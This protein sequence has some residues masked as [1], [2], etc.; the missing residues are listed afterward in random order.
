MDDHV[1]SVDSQRTDAVLSYVERAEGVTCIACRVVLCGHEAVMSLVTGFKDVPRCLACLA[2]A[3]D[4]NRR[5]LRDHL[6]AYINHHECYRE[7]WQWVSGREGFAP[8]ASP[9]CLWAKEEEMTTPLP[10]GVGH[11]ESEAP[12]GPTANAE[13]NA[14]DIGCGDLVMELRRRLQSMK[15]GEVLKVTARDPGAPE[16]LPAW[17]RLTGHTLTHWGHSEYWI[18]RKEE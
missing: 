15:P 7:G 17:C 8:T 3:L 5:E 13:W 16:D 9:S 10:D 11:S 18:R 4:W 1:V 12:Q 2:S 6:F 14:G